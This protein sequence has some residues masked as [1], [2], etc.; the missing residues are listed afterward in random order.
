MTYLIEVFFIRPNVYFLHLLFI[1]FFNAGL[2]LVLNI[3]VLPAFLL[4]FLPS[5]SPVSE[6]KQALKILL[7]P[8]IT[9]ASLIMAKVILFHFP[10]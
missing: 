7:T 8:M 1:L 4:S 9:F 5:S 10:C 2:I 3:F 6:V